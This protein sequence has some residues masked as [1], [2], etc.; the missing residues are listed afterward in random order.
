[1]NNSINKLA[2]PLGTMLQQYCIE[3]VLGH[4]G[5]GIV[6]K[7]RHISLDLEVAIKEYF[8]QSF[9]TRDEN[10]VYPL[11]DSE[12]EDFY[13][14]IRRFLVEAKQ[15]VKFDSHPNVVKCR[16]FFEANG[17]AY[18]V[19]NFEDGEELSEILKVRQAQDKP[20]SERQI[21]RIIR[22]IL[23]GLKDIH[24]ANVLHRDIKPAN[25]F[26]RRSTEDPVL[27]DFGAAKG[28]F[29]TQ[30]KTSFVHTGGY[31]PMEQ[32]F[33]NGQLGPWTDL[34][35]VGAM[36]WRIIANENPPKVELRDMA[37]NRGNPDPMTPAVE[38]GE[39]NFS[40]A[41]LQAIEKSLKIDSKDR[42]QSAAE[43]LAALPLEAPVVGSI[44]DEPLTVPVSRKP[45]PPVVPIPAKP[46]L[47]S[48]KKATTQESER[49]ASV[50]P[51]YKLG[52]AALFVL[53]VG[54]F[55]IFFFDQNQTGD[56]KPSR[57]IV[58]SKIERLY[59]QSNRV[60]SNLDIQNGREIDLKTLNNLASMAKESG[61]DEDY[62][63]TIK[64]IQRLKTAMQETELII[65]HSETDSVDTAFELT[66]YR[67]D[68]RSHIDE[69]FE[70]K[71][72]LERE[73]G[74]V[75]KANLLDGFYL[76]IKKT[77]KQ[78]D[79]GAAKNFLSEKLNLRN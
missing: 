51:I 14:G 7:A 75:G 10:T 60:Q 8:P 43:F 39:G 67:K 19:M 74:S 32:I 4:G 37:L 53:A 28:N 27:I 62:Q 6:Y 24:S 58:F 17:T 77:P 13:D 44:P 59:E 50:F 40:I 46:G 47:A 2:L 69:L 35:A 49:Q 72:E 56:A 22:P 26:V 65:M 33:E 16:D 52:I 66:N 11:S 78:D 18:L 12:E 3:E 34:Y 79:D 1:M 68:W 41:F 30:E 61:D 31:A 73:R 71:I 63:D 45:K 48:L 38:L 5:F 21:L 54:A 29:S 20:L 76:T 42:F 55:G 70:E 23:G 57:D 15:L 36:M 64:Q 9:A 25:I